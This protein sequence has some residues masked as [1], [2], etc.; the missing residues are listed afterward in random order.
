MATEREAEARTLAGRARRAGPWRPWETVTRF[1]RKKP[2]GAV[3]GGIILALVTIAAT[4][5]WITFYDPLAWDLPVKLLPPGASHWLGTDEMGRDLWSRIV[6]GAQISLQV[7]FASVALGSGVGG[8]LGITSAWYGGR[9]DQLM[10]R[11]LDALM[12]IPTL[13]LALAITAS[14]GQSLTN[15]ILAIAVTQIPR[16]NRI[17]RSQA[18]SVK[19]AD[20]VLAAQALGASDARI[21]FRH[22]LPQ[23]VAPWLIIA[24][25]GLGAAIL[26]EASLSFLG[27][28]VPAPEPS[29]GGML[30]GPARNYYAVAPWMAIWPGLALSLAVYGFNLFGDALR[31]VL[32]PRLR[33]SQ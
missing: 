23:C 17:V 5:P 7:G 16:A 13:I 6:M 3:G 29:W 4:A 9:V 33:G 32:D 15:I 1:V 19:Q 26:I 10:Q 22:I 12:S 20:F 18:L 30:S 21:M 25:A 8:L 14:L 27:L 24:S 28:G 31:D 11:L 2:L